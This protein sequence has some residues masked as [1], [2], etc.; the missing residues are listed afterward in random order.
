MNTISSSF[1][2]FEQG[3]LKDVH[4]DRQEE[5]RGIDTD[6]NGTLEDGEIV[7]YL[8]RTDSMHDHEGHNIDR[9]RVL[10][11]FKY[12][13]KKE[14]NPEVAGYHS[15]EQVKADLEALERSYPHLARLVSLGKSPEGRDL[16][17]LQISKGVRCEDTSKKPGVVI[18]GCH[19]AREWMSMEAPLHVAHQLLE[20]YATDPEMRRRV[21]TGEIWVAPLVNPDGYEYSRNEDSWWRKSRRPVG[22]D[23]CGRE[24]S[25]VGVDL[26]RNYASPKPELAYLYRPEG[27]TPC[28]TSDDFGW[29]TSDHPNSDTYRGPAPASEP[30]IQA[31]LNLELNRGNI[32]GVI[33]HHGYGEMILHPW[34]HTDEPVNGVDRYRSVGQRMNQA[35]GPNEPFRV[36]HGADLYPTSGTSDDVLHASGIFN[37]TLEIGRSFQPPVSQIDPIRTSVARAN[38]VFIDEVLANGG[39]H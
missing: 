10:T 3:E 12:H 8:Q 26:N 37:Y 39:V 22:K 7:D 35:I 11:E 27:D 23:A 30:E 38:M 16:W 31:L 24:T 25:A 29:A 18:T 4:P 32:Q 13:L 15:Y 20:G 14:I 1:R 33:D 5:A 34:G 6:Q 36:M 9:D 21:D 28:S 19:H 17:A 2:F